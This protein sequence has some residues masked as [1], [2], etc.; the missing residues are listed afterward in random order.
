[1]SMKQILLDN[2][3]KALMFSAFF[4][5]LAP[6]F[7]VIG[8][9][10]FGVSLLI[11]NEFAPSFKGLIKSKVLLMPA[12]LFLIYVL[13]I[14]FTQ[15]IN[16]GLKDLISKF[17][18]LLF[19]LFLATLRIEKDDL[20]KI[21]VSFGVGVLAL[22]IILFG[23]AL[24]DFYKDGNTDVFFY[25]S[26]TRK[27][28][29]TYF[30]VFMN[31]AL[32]FLLEFIYVRAKPFSKVLM[33]LFFVLFLFGVL[34][35]IL[36]SSR[37]AIIGAGVSVMY[38]C[39]YSVFFRKVISI[40]SVLLIIGIPVLLF[41]G[42]NKLFSSQ[43]RFRAIE[44]YVAS[45][46][47]SDE[48]SI[49]ARVNIW[50]A[51]LSLIKENLF[52]GVGTGDVDEELHKLYVNEN[53]AYALSKNLNMHNQFIQTFVAVGIFGF[54]LLCSLMIIPGLMALKRGDVLFSSFL[55]IVFL[56][57]ITES[58]LERQAGMLLFSFFY[59]LFASAK[60]YNG[61]FTKQTSH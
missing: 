50:K 8:M 49:E 23:K 56:N 37:M 4:L 26:F 13:G 59:A 51:S 57:C 10:L 22:G 31:V 61:S 2:R 42:I 17:P 38:W 34:E 55:L 3:T 40:R 25:A 7:S 1:M 9:I 44:T 35:I 36:A 5:S 11:T 52:T 47:K 48:G 6:L 58:F 53:L 15:N 27:L 19:P 54:L 33:W 14:F 60:M 43:N 20:I 46:V 16:N 32:I 41:L 18:L 12:L 24:F 30:T 45:N 21:A 28:H 39:I 29:P